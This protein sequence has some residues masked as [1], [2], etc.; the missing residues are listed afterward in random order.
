M[1]E[2]DSTTGT[3]KDDSSDTLTDRLL[4]AQSDPMDSTIRGYLEAARLRILHLEST[5]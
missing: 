1:T 3:A 2:F 5:Q 4:H